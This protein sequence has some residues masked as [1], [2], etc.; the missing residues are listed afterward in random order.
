MGPKN[1]LLP[2]R[3]VMMMTVVESCRSML[4]VATKAVS[5]AHN[6]PARP[7]TAAPMTKLVSL[8]P[9][10]S[11]PRNAA[12]SSFCFTAFTAFPNAVRSINAHVSA[13]IIAHMKSTTK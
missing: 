13:A 12:R 6:V 7:A 10:V 5:M 1:Q 11:Y 3:N 8:T 4:S 9:N 2:P